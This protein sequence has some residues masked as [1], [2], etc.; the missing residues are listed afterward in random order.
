MDRQLLLKQIYAQLMYYTNLHYIK[1]IGYVR[2]LKATQLE[3]F[4]EAT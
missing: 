2:R 1:Y 3:A 4:G